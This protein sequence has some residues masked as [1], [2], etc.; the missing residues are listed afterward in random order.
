M[1]YNAK[2]NYF[3]EASAG[4]GK[5]YNIIEYLKDVLPTVNNNISRFLI[6]T[7]TEKAVE[8]LKNRVR[9]KIKGIDP[10]KSEIYTI[11]S[12]C[13]RIISEYCKSIKKPI[14]LN[15][16]DESKASDFVDSFLRDSSIAK[17][18]AKIK[19]R[20]DS[21]NIK[22]VKNYFV[23][24]LDKYYLDK[25]VIS[26]KKDINRIVYDLL[27]LNDYSELASVNKELYDEIE[28]LNGP[29]TSDALKEKYQKIVDVINNKPIGFNG[30]IGIKPG[31]KE[32][33][34]Q[35]I[36]D[37]LM[38]VKKVEI[39]EVYQYIV[40]KYIDELYNEWIKEKAKREEQSF[41]DMIRFVREEIVNGD[42]TLKNKIQ[43]KYDYA[44][45]DE[46]QDTNKLQ[47]DIFSNTFL[48]GK[49]NL[50]V[51]G[52]PKQSIY[53][54]QGADVFVYNN[55]IDK[56][57]GQA[58][59]KVLDYN[60]RAS[61]NMINATNEL[62][63]TNGFISGFANFKDSKYPP[64][65]DKED[66]KIAKYDGEDFKPICV[67][68][69]DGADDGKL[70][71]YDFAKIA[72]N[73]I[74]ECTEY[75]NKKT[76]LQIASGKKDEDGNTEL[77]DVTFKD[78]T[79]LVKIKSEADAIRN[80]L[81]RVGIP[82]VFYKDDKLFEGRECANWIAL[83]QA[84]DAIDFTGDRNKIFRRAL[85]TDFF[86]KSLEEI[87]DE[88]YD[89]DGTDE[90]KMI[91]HFKDIAKN[92][93]YDD[94]IDSIIIETGLERR[95]SSLDKIQSLSTYEQ[96]GD[97]AI[98][99]LTNNHTLIDLI[100]KL[101]MLNNKDD[102]GEDLGDDGDLVGRS[103]DFNCVQIMTIHASKGL[104][105]PVVIFGGNYAPPRKKN[106]GNA[107]LV[108]DNKGNPQI[109]FE[110]ND[111][112][113][114]EQS[115]EWRRLFYVAFTRARYLL[116]IPNY[117]VQKD[118]C[119]DK[120]EVYDFFDEILKEFMKNN[121]Y[122]DLINYK[123][124]IKNYNLIKEQKKVHDILNIQKG[125]LKIGNIDD[126][127]DVISKLIDTS[128]NK[129]IYKHSY[130]S[131][132][133]TQTKEKV[134][135][136]DEELDIDE[137]NKEDEEVQE[138]LRD[139]DKK[140]IVV[141]DNLDDTKDPVTLSNNYPKGKVIGTALHEVFELL[142][143]DNYDESLLRKTISEAF[144]NNSIKDK[145][146]WVDNTVDMVNEVMKAKLPEIH[147][148][149][150]E[151]N[152]Y[153][154]LKDIDED[155]KKAEVE[156]NFS[157]LNKHLNNNVRGLNCAT[158]FVDLIFKRGE[159]YSILDWKSDKLN[160]EDLINYYDKDSLTN[161]T[162]NHYSIQRVLYS[163][164]LIKW[165]KNYYP[166]E[167]EEDIFNNH[168]GGVYYVYIRGCNDG[169]SNGIYAK[170]WN[171]FSELEKSYTEIMQKRIGGK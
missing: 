168:F 62:F 84:I 153:F 120:Y 75:V 167:S 43:D 68:Y 121:T 159:Y 126:Q 90:M 114:L 15:I 154:S 152:K 45:I 72:V 133:H 116:V 110:K 67:A 94:L 142:P 65:K 47:W 141:I 17:V 144:K 105:F 164:T 8:E 33:F 147:G 131:L 52:D 129:S 117:N 80:E 56:M 63:K 97:F 5:T 7:Y 161:R 41:N 100:R 139:F 58:E 137:P 123:D 125:S 24:M 59:P 40:I 35:D 140:G 3:I 11:H 169:T 151:T 93:R 79:I 157:F 14:N 112:Y 54:F 44:I 23:S 96:I 124:F 165:L 4:T 149:R 88:K 20:Y 91:L 28:I 38:N 13:E 162:N 163:H 37:K 76:R 89:L 71:D 34:A 99:Y 21:L 106:D 48:S 22:T 148:S 122:C 64:Y 82:Y 31:K 87:S 170:T 102:D 85:F 132:S 18:L 95:L 111:K 2:T 136:V 78:F 46:F 155:S 118:N 127:K 55:A 32:S 70:G 60:Y 69:N 42:G 130:S 50:V 109:D 104:E 73:K 30:K 107:F 49:N 158:G 27:F 19:Q 143:F 103:T 77:R 1:S 51:V 115:Q 25:T 26:I 128:S 36:H 171:S 6:V 16:I 61:E 39:K 156:F 83:L 135:G 9:N 113:Y 101:T 145:K 29:N 66:A 119:T 150:H 81:Q 98:D 146:E 160:D 166:N 53:S 92:K 108:H 138:S 57:R 12:F 134:D 86:D 10:E 74:V